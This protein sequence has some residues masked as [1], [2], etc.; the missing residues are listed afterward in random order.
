MGIYVNIMDKINNVLKYVLFLFLFTS[1]VTLFLQVIFRFVLD[2]PL[3]WTDELSRYL[4][5]WITFIG[6]SLAVRYNQLIKLEVLLT[7]MPANFKRIIAITAG[8]I[9]FVFYGLLIY[10]GIKILATVNIQKSPALHLSMAVP[11]AAIPVGAFLMLCNTIAKL[12]DRK[13][14][15]TES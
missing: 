4:M 1:M 13:K 5:V 12:L 15:V 6:A 11:Y 8:I 2:A 3:S 9:T 14:G 7:N 10:F